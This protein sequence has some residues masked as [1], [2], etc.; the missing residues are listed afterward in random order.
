MKEKELQN[1]VLDYLASVRV[2][3]WPNAAVSVY[4]PVRKRF[5]KSHN[6]HSRNGIPDILAILPGGVFLGIEL[7]KP[8]VGKRK[9]QTLFNMMSEDQQRFMAD[10]RTMGAVCFVADSLDTVRAIVEP[11][12]GR[13]TYPT[14]QAPS[15]VH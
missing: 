8:P 5:R 15:G 3:A 12:L 11:L 1:L 6:K 9:E 13:A 10:A 7:K 14:G 4:D 2:M